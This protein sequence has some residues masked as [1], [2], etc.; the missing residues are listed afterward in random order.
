MEGFEEVQMQKYL[1]MR[2]SLQETAS[3]F[4][5]LSLGEGSEVNAAKGSLLARGKMNQTGRWQLD[6]F[7]KRLQSGKRVLPIVVHMTSLTA[8]L[9][10]APAFG[11]YH[12]A[13][14]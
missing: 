4:P 9:D 6:C 13:F 14:S 12:K 7:G 10:T 2:V 1:K 3:A 11:V 5:G 8:P